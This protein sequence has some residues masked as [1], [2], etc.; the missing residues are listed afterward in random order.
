MF[1]IWEIEFAR[2]LL[3][4]QVANTL[5][6]DISLLLSNMKR[7]YFYL[8]LPD[9]KIN[10]DFIARGIFD[11]TFINSTDANITK[12][13]TERINKILKLKQRQQI[14]YVKLHNIC[15]KTEYR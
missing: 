2:L 13:Q 6:N 12:Y 10:G 1:D 4:E 14:K 8:S 7:N 15:K 3:C 11:K 5:R 9:Y